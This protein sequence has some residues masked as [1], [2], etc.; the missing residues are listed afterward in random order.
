MNLETVFNF[1]LPRGYVDRAGNLHRTGQ[2]K[3]ANAMDEIGPLR[4]PRVR[5]NP[6]YHTIILLAR[7]VTQLG[8]LPAIDTGTIEGL[9][10]VDL[11]FLQELYRQKN[12]LVQDPGGQVRCPSCGEQFQP[13]EEATEEEA[14]SVPLAGMPA[15]TSG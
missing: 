4:D 15:T 12:E 9:F 8:S 6:A 2:M 1:T 3:L 11:A 5:Q 14:P 7:V 13:M 10:T